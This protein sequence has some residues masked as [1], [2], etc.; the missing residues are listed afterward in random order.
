MPLKKLLV[1]DDEVGIQ[2][3]LRRVLKGEGYDVRT[4]GSGEEGVSMAQDDA[5]DLVL[6]D[7]KMPGMDGIETL[8]ALKDV[9]D[10]IE[11]I[12]LT[13]H[14]TVESAVAAMKL[15]AADYLKKPFD[16]DEL[17]ITIS[18]CLG[19]ADL[20]KENI[21]L[22]EDA[23]LRYGLDCIVGAAPKMQEIFELIK[24]VAP[25]P[26]TVLIQGESG[27]GK[28]L[29]AGSIHYLSPRRHKRFIKVN[30]A[31]ISEELLESELFGHEKGA[32]TGAV[33]SAEGKFVMADGGSIL[34][35]EVSEMSPK[36]QA[37]LLRV[38]QEKEVDRVGGREPIPVDVR[39]MASTNRDLEEAI[40]KG[41]F[42]EDL[43]YR[44]N[45]VSIAFPPLRERKSDIPELVTHFVERFNQEMNKRIEGLA[46]DVE[47]ALMR[48]SW[49]G[50]VR[51]LQNC[52]ERA[53]V[54]CKGSV[55][56][57]QHLPP[58]VAQGGAAPGAGPSL[59][60]PSSSIEVGVTVAEMERQLIF[61]TLEHTQYNRT[62]AAEIL[63]ISIRT[64]R[65]KLNEYK[66]TGDLPEMEKVGA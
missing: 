48:Y 49:P 2:N 18:K 65:N 16:V 44:L 13:A 55:I 26:S 54:L 43:Y 28:E 24:T 40:K 20:K 41:E 57:F 22:R 37:K 56:Q 15:G 9:S 51:Q 60:E 5:P 27:T 3:L 25:T 14:S 7:I 33:R 50:N 45:V 31:A 53:I 36:L 39:V 58:D 10:E 66:K 62:R 46:P 1:V 59:A 21:Q 29:I 4:A 30:C 42:R 6:C 8:A 47:D 61:K 32:F 34:L 38:L 12:M 11:V 64:L 23:G 63:G 52:I 17:K 35:D 19:V